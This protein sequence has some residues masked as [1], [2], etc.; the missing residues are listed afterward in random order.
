MTDCVL[1]NGVVQISIAEI[2]C[3]PQLLWY[4]A[5]IIEFNVSQITLLRVES[6]ASK[7]A[8]LKRL[9]EL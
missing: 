3:P 9:R 8:E 2:V 5:A 4:G 1:S 7:T 6:I